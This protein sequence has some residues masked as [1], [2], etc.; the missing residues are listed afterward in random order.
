MEYLQPLTSG[1]GAMAGG[2]FG[3][4]LYGAFTDTLCY[5]EELVL[6]FWRLNNQS[7]KRTQGTLTLVYETLTGY[8]ME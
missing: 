7:G 5:Y 4:P 3:Y 6:A 1:S 2:A 8:T